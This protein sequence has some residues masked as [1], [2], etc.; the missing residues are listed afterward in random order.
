MPQIIPMKELRNT[1]AIS[2]LCNAKQEPVFVTKNGYG[3]LVIM[4]IKTYEKIIQSSH[5]DD[6]IASAEAELEA[7]GELL[8]A[9]TALAELRKKNCILNEQK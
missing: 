9:K 2:E 8:D 5:I 3:D 6:A 7:G 4:S 1:N